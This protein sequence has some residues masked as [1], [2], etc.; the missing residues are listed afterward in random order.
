MLTDKGTFCTLRSMTHKIFQP[1]FAA[2]PTRAKMVEDTGESE[3]TVKQWRNRDSV[4]ARAWPTLVAKA[5]E[6]GYLTPDGK[7]ITQE[8]LADL[9][10]QRRSPASD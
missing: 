8:L 1:V 10:A 5:K 9:Y 6:H 3:N 4:P 7:E 2:W